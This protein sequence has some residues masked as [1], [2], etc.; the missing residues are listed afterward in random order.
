MNLF[1][2]LH[3]LVQKRFIIK[4]CA[5]IIVLVL[6]LGK[7]NVVTHATNCPTTDYDCQIA[8]IQRE[9]DALSSAHEYNKKEL[10]DL[11]VQL[12]NLDVRISVISSELE[13]LDA[14]IQKREVELAFTRK[15]FEEKTHDHYKFMRF[16]DPLLPFLASS[17]ASTAFR[18]IN[19]RRKAAEENKS[20]IE[21]YA[22]QLVL[23]KKDKDS[24]VAN[25]KNL[26]TAKAGVVSREQFLAGEVE[27]TETYL[28]ELSKKQEE[29]LAAKAGSFTASVGDSELADDYY[30]S[31]KGFRESA[32]SGSFAVFSFGAYTHRKGMSQYGA[33]GRAEN[34]QNASQILQAYYGKSPVNKDTS[35]TILVDGVAMDF[36]NYYLYGIAEMPSSW[37]MEALKA[38][39]IAAR[40]YAYRYKV[41]GT[42]IC[43]TEACQVYRSSKA[44]NP[45]DAW[46][47]A[48]DSTRG[49]VLEDVVT[50]YSSTSG[51]YLTTS[52]WDTTDGS[53]GSNFVD[54]AW[55]SRGG[56][57]W[58]YKAW[59]RQG[60]TSSGATCGKNNPW[61][62][63]QEM[64]DIINA[65]VVIKNTNDDRVSP[66]TSCW[67]GNP[68]SFDELRNVASQYGGIS[69][70][71]SIS[72]TQ[73]DGS[74]NSVVV[75]GSL[76]LSGA[77]F[78]K[79][80]NLRAPGYLA[81]PQSGFAFFN[82]EKK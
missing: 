76:T 3:P 61:L 73:G 46:R 23:L 28:A 77:E 35:G 8:E 33:R 22:E 4:W 30:A 53:G 37:H 67:G 80:F 15:I 20:D 70:V 42:S 79:G 49:Q 65:A 45:P 81:I 38:Q 54:K 44:A 34:G 36:E 24:L 5:F 26:A 47:Q 74:T 1:N 6:L 68:Y 48:V 78:K 50:Y 69:S 11:R 18:E 64:T 58:L 56:S 62:S 57:P 16:Y 40:T 39:A 63:N 31:I 41:Q 9:I 25:Q 19:F 17:D 10:Q 59:Y 12:K 51:G 32:P 52:G 71:S 75:N 13:A 66:T 2:I 27:S 21:E 72:V 82:I 29:V 7:N 55:E 14:D 43:T 60:Y